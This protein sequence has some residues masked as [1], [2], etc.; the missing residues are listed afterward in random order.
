[1]AGTMT[2]KVA[3]VTGGSSGIGRATC[4]RFAQEGA[5]VVLA[6]R[7]VA[8]GEQT[9]QLVREAGGEALFVRTDVARPADVQALVTTCLTRYGRLDYACNNAGTEGAIGPL[10]ECSEA[11][12]DTI[13][14]TKSLSDMG[15]FVQNDSGVSL[16]ENL[17]FS[18]TC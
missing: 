18:A 2:G 15:A 10:V 11:Q 5:A 13:I 17:G 14:G 3:L 7:R 16:A 6:A 8:E 1:M 4:V 9:A 12:W